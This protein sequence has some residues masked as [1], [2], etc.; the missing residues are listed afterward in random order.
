VATVRSDYGKSPKDKS[1]GFL[2]RT[3]KKLRATHDF[4]LNEVRAI[5]QRGEPFPIPT[6]P[7]HDWWDGRHLKELDVR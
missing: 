1:H 4:D 7:T 5:V 3:K 2:T 6:T